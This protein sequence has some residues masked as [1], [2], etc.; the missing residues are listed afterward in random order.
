MKILVAGA[1]GQVARSLNELE[2]KSRHEIRCLGRPEFDI[3]DKDSV[4]RVF[5]ENEFD[6]LINAAAYT[7][8]DAA[9]SDE[10]AAFATNEI[11]V[12]IL[13]RAT[14]RLK[15]PI[16]HIS[17]DYVF[18]GTADDPYLEDMPVCPLGVYG[19]SKLDGEVSLR[20]EN[21]KHLI[22]R[23]A[24]VYSPFGKNFVKTMLRLAEDR[25][26]VSVVA[27]Q[28]GSP[29]YAVDI[30]RTLLALA[31]EL[32]RTGADDFKWGTYHLAC[33][34]HGSWADVA[35]E[36]FAASKMLG[37]PT[38]SVRRITSAEYPT[39]VTRPANSRLDTNKLQ[40]TFDI[41]LPNWRDSVK[42]C[43]ERLIT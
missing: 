7:A 40:Q 14:E 4:S 22:L 25:D 41:R 12:G 30:A 19:K 23:T 8:V 1:N 39:P 31:D 38:A 16:F 15:R 11:G 3:S 13:A 6:L 32:D 10:E 37:G 33:S 28:I 2:A 36:V 17:T 42:A 5:A 29:T 9:E 26:E 20:Q 24:W 27:D 43:V 35:E 18:D 34:D 21:P